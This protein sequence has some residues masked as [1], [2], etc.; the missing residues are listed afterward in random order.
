M[1]KQTG[2]PLRFLIVLIVTCLLAGLV[3][4]V[5]G[6]NMTFDGI[7][8]PDNINIPSI[9]QSNS[10][11]NNDQTESPSVQGAQ[12]DATSDDSNQLDNGTAASQ[13]TTSTH[14]VVSVTDGDTIRVQN[15]NKTES[16]RLIG[17]DT[18]E[19]HDTRTGVQCFGVEAAGYVR[20]QLN[21]AT[22]KLVPDPTQQNRDKYDR[23]LRYVFLSDGTHINQKI[24]AE[25]YGF[26]YTYS[27]PYRYRTEFIA[28][29]SNA[30]NSQKG[31]WSAT[32]C[33]GKVTQN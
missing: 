23:L 2:K 27:V 15:G 4:R 28:A 29:Q 7:S 22:V 26:E 21:G 17:I 11:P 14:K 24:I 6:V 32:T 9:D 33:S 25:G 5:S 1:P 13:P 31:L 30:K 20:E 8:L 3:T 12:T 18:P 10:Q 16:V 19:L